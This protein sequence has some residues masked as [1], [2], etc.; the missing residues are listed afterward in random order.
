MSGFDQRH[1]DFVP[2]CH[3][4]FPDSEFEDGEP[5]YMMARKLNRKTGAAAKERPV[6]DSFACKVMPYDPM[7][8]PA[9]LNARTVEA[10]MKH[11]TPERNQDLKQVLKKRKRH[12]DQPDTP[13]KPRGAF[14]TFLNDEKDRLQKKDLKLSMPDLTKISSQRWKSM[15]DEEKE[16]YIEQD[17]RERSDFQTKMQT[18]KLKMKD[19][20]QKHPDWHAI[21]SKGDS[22]NTLNKKIK[23]LPYKN[24]FNKVVKLNSDGQ[25]EAGDEFK[26]YYVLTYIPDLFWCH[27]APM[28]QNGYFS[29]KSRSVG[30]PKWKLV[31]EGAGKELDIS[32]DVCEIVKARTM[33]GCADADKE[34]WDILD[35]EVEV[36]FSNIVIPSGKFQAGSPSPK[37]ITVADDNMSDSAMSATGSMKENDVPSSNLKPKQPRIIQGRTPRARMSRTVKS[38]S[39]KSVTTSKSTPNK[40]KLMSS[41]DLHI[42]ELRKFRD[43]YGHCRVPKPYKQNLSLSNWISNLNYSR[44]LSLKGL[45]ATI[46]LSED[47]L[48]KLSE[49]GFEFTHMEVGIR[50]GGQVKRG[51]RQKNVSDYTLEYPRPFKKNKTDNTIAS[52]SESAVTDCQRSSGDTFV[53]KTSVVTAH[54][55]ED[56]DSQSVPEMHADVKMDFMISPMLEKV[57]NGKQNPRAKNGGF[58]QM[59]LQKYFKM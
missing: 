36:D 38:S 9:V 19:F 54:E 18:Y 56:C 34:E 11:A 3:W 24:L 45:P 46:K 48:E 26:Y 13:K 8:I 7:S 44:S 31:H 35:D 59:S 37:S 53:D 47:R 40:N 21:G 27:L 1:D 2:Y 58:I 57:R 32:A 22:S 42:K 23:K 4:T 49:L 52:I 14:F 20:Y 17:K 33:R 16:P 10:P 43:Q 25:H 55:N 30:R 51:K 15:P 41:F 50:G 12:P 6:E 29:Q 39:P 5:S 28:R